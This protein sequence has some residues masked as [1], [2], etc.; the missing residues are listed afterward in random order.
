MSE[1]AALVATTPLFD[2]TRRPLPTAPT[3]RDPHEQAELDARLFV[4]AGS[5]EQPVGAV[6][7][8]LKNGANPNHANQYNIAPLHVAARWGTREKVE[9]LLRAGAELNP[10]TAFGET[11]AHWAAHWANADSLRALADAGASLAREDK[12]GFTPAIALE[13][14]QHN[15]SPTDL[16]ETRAAIAAIE[17]QRAPAQGGFSR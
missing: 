2:A 8:A 11:P 6:L 10:L 16:A 5:A 9:A 4:A 14:N 17:R 3:V 15:V 7:S 13:A 1:I 12:R